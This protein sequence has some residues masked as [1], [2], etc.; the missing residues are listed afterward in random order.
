MDKSRGF[1]LYHKSVSLDFG[2]AYVFDD[3]LFC[4]FLCFYLMLKKLRKSERIYLAITFRQLES[5]GYL[6]QK[7]APNYL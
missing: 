7:R 5:I 1:V 2:L 4:V 6:G 3:F